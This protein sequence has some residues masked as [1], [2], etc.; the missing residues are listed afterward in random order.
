LQN[1]Y[2]VD[3]RAVTVRYSPVPVCNARVR[4]GDGSLAESGLG[5]QVLRR[6][7]NVAAERLRSVQ[8]PVR[9]AEQLASEENQVG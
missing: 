9:V 8:R 2:Q 5:G 3:D 7:G 4:L 1:C 6:I